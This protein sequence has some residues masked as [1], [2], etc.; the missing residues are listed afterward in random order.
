MDIERDGAA[1][2]YHI[3]GPADGTAVVM[4]HSLG[5]SSVMWE[6]QLPALTDAY[7]VVRFDTRGHGDS[8]A[9]DEPYSLDQLAGDAAAVIEAEAS[10]PVHWIGLSMGGMIGQTLAL[11]RPELLR[12]LMLCDTSAQVPADGQAVWDDRIAAV[13]EEGM[14]ALAEPTM[15]RW[16]TPNYLREDPP[17]VLPIRAQFEA[18][19]VA[20]YAGC[21]EAIR[22]L[23]NLTRLHE[24]ELP[25][26][27]IVGE[28]DP[29][30]P[31]AA[32]EAMQREI[33]GAELVVLPNASHLSN[34]E[35][36]EAFNDAMR[37]FLDRN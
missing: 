22:R 2:A 24:I 21:C 25:T 28:D 7:R 33:A 18:T 17:A 15:Q 3:D 20:G 14:A 37:G 4:S 35:Q 5:S 12:S 36:E 6:P 34:V 1:I 9:P 13:R 30:T 8:G 32:S 23:D 11:K 16:F 26:L 29:G 19:D 27:I 31:V 10:A